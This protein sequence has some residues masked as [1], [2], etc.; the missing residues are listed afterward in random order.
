MADGVGA[1]QIGEPAP[2]FTSKTAT[3]PRYVFDTLGGRAIV[4]GFFGALRSRAGQHVQRVINAHRQVFD[5]SR[6]VFLG[7]G[8]DGSEVDQLRS[9]Q[10]G[11]LFLHDFNGAVAQSYG[12]L[13]VD[14]Q[15]GQARLSPRWIVIDPKLTIREIIPMRSDG[16]DEGAMLSAV[17]ALVEEFGALSIGAPV[18]QLPAVFEPALCRRLIALHEGDGGVESGFVREVNG[19]TVLVHDRDHKRRRD[20]VISDPALIDLIRDRISRRVVPSIKRSFQFE[21][22]RMERYLVGCYLAEESG[23]FRPHRDNTTRGTAHRRFAVSISLNDGFAG[24]ELR[25]PEYGSHR[26]RAPA[27]SAIVFSCSLLHGV[28]PVTEGRRYVFL[29]FL[30]DEAAAGIRQANEPFLDSPNSG[31]A[32]SPAARGL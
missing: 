32:S 12:A 10:S 2:W 9:E 14:L 4:L 8:N 6:A 24:G 19:R 17:E 31:D 5:G 20:H 22:T 23:H 30:Y 25:F 27:G 1:L 26:Y 16:S 13:G 7:I 11:C 18:L 3:N 21:A 28:T 29:P 15:G